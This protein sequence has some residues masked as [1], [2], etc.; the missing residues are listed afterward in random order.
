M[1]SPAANITS[2][3]EVTINR[4]VAPVCQLE[5]FSVLGH[6][7]PLFPARF[8]KGCPC[9]KTLCMAKNGHKT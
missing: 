8:P 5:D 6:K 3:Q 9:A 7:W 2:R 1:P 4:K